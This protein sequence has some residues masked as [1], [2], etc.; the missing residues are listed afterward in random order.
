VQAVSGGL[1][2]L[3]AQ[4]S[5]ENTLEVCNTVIDDDVLYKLTFFFVRS[6][7]I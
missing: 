3:A 6:A 5:D 1:G 7:S 2:G 4:F